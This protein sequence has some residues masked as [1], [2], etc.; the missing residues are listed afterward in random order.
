MLGAK[1]AALEGTEDAVVLSSGMAAVA[2]SML[3]LLQPGDHFLTQVTG[4][5]RPLEFASLAWQ[6]FVQQT[7]CSWG[8]VLLEATPTSSREVA[9]CVLRQLLLKPLYWSAVSA[10]WGK[11][12]AVP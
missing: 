1:L 9:A 3:T 5:C 7:A 12:C 2:T 6:L 10:V 8:D 11:P 4:Y